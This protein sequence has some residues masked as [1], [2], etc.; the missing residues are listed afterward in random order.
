[1]IVPPSINLTGDARVAQTL[2]SRAMQFYSFVV[3]QAE[4]GGVSYVNRSLPLPGGS[5]INISS[6]K[7]GNY[8][9]RT[10]SVVI[11][12]AFQP[13]IPP[14]IGNL[15]FIY[16]DIALQDKAY[17][18]KEN[19][20]SL[21]KRA[22]GS[23]DVDKLTK[24]LDIGAPFSSTYYN[25]NVVLDASTFSIPFGLWYNKNGIVTFFDEN[26]IPF[27]LLISDIYYSG[28]RK[29]ILENVYHTQYYEWDVIDKTATLLTSK[30]TGLYRKDDP[31]PA[32]T[33]N[34]KYG[35][36]EGNTSVWSRGMGENTERC[37]LNLETTYSPNANLVLLPNPSGGV[38]S[39]LT[40]SDSEGI[41]YT[42]SFG[43]QGSYR[44]GS[45]GFPEFFAYSNVT[46]AS[47]QL[48]NKA[49]TVFGVVLS[50]PTSAIVYDHFVFYDA[51]YQDLRASGTSSNYI[52]GT[53]TN[54]ISTYYI[55]TTE[56]DKIIEVKVVDDSLP[57]N[58]FVPKESNVLA[59]NIT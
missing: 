10:G 58:L 9:L 14:K 30:P 28:G 29:F 55:V 39:L 34:D 56:N 49:L 25:N 46:V 45:V 23:F 41:K 44:Y 43:A 35:I 1:M 16:L 6:Y 54:V 38:S 37:R 20:V 2:K 11:F 12:G 22:D 27:E 19:I 47:M 32:I 3:R 13:P 36:F 50:V 15:V 59:L 26:E 40:I 4:I 53:Y 7:D 17:T 18:L 51:L 57:L 52:V 5:L 33:S 42:A 31:V 24:D 48:D 8:G 21:P